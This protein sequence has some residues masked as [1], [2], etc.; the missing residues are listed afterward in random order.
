MILQRGITSFFNWDERGPIPEFSFA[1][2]KSI[3]FAVAAPRGYAVSNVVER[4]VTPNFHSALLSKGAD[5]VSIL[6]HSAYPILAFAEPLEISSCRLCFVDSDPLSREIRSLF[7]EVT[8]AR[9]N[10]LNRKLE[11]R[12][13]EELDPAELAQVKYWNPQTIGDVAFNWWD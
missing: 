9:A 13:L 3:V 7:C 1:E 5:A 12:D 8:V 11:D 4:G 6:G 10:D 2:F